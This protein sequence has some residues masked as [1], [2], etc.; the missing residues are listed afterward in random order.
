MTTCES[1]DKHCASKMCDVTIQ[2]D[3]KG[4]EMLHINHCDKDG[5]GVIK[6][7]ASMRGSVSSTA[8]I[9]VG[10]NIPL[11]DPNFVETCASR[12]EQLYNN[13]ARPNWK[14]IVVFGSAHQ[15]SLYV[16]E[17]LNA[18]LLPIQFIGFT[19]EKYIQ[20]IF[21]YD[22]I[23]VIGCDHDRVD[24]LWMWCKIANSKQIPPTYKKIIQNASNI[25]IVRSTDDFMI[26]NVDKQ[27]KDVCIGTIPSNNKV[28]ENTDVY[29]HN[30]IKLW[31]H[32]EWYQAN[33]DI[34]VPIAY[35]SQTTRENKEKD[36]MCNTTGQIRLWNKFTV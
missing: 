5:T 35:P 32:G 8:T 28:Y 9:G 7:I 22:F 30:S 23:K 34:I 19:R 2:V 1:C 26:E 14:N 16:A 20:N 36:K 25:V 4:K 17:V 10:S 6:R 29:V 31:K 3:E 18:P 24:L 11:L 15:A 13:Y 21:N 27:L 33:K 12:I